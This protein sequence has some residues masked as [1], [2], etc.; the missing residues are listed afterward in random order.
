[1]QNSQNTLNNNGLSALAR[2]AAPHVLNAIKRASAATGVSFA[3]MMQK[4]SAESSFDTHAKSRTSSATGLYQ[5]IESTWL[6]MVKKYGDKCGLSRYAACIDD[7]GRVAD[8]AMKKEILALRKNPEAA[9][10]MAAEFTAENKA[11]LRD[12]LGPHAKIGPTEL[13]L[14]HFFGAGGAT[15]FMKEMKE[16]PLQQASDLFPKAAGANRAVFNDSKTGA[17]RTL[18]GAS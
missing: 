12:Q 14:A 4:A 13:Y 10:M 5:F 1:M 9:A 15:A 17:P 3:Y 11:Y 2:Q 8:P 7:N 16:N 6:N 18:A